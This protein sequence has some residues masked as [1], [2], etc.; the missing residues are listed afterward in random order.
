[1]KTAKKTTRILDIIT[2]T[3]FDNHKVQNLT[4]AKWVIK[5]LPP[6]I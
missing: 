5:R 4:I 1:M 3:L 2:S 6:H